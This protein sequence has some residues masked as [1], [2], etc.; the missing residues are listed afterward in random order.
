MVGRSHPVA[1]ELTIAYLRVF[2]SLIRP[3]NT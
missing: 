1:V 2:D 3:K